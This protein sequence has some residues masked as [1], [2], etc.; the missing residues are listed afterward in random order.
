MAYDKAKFQALRSLEVP[1]K[2]ALALSDDESPLNAGMAAAVEDLEVDA[3]LPTTVAK[4]NEL[5]DALRTAGL[6]EE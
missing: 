2:L 3:D 6:L 1:Y 4:V 5:L